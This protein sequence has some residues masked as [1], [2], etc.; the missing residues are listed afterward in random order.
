[1]ASTP[2]K[3]RKNSSLVWRHA[4]K[5]FRENGTVKHIKC[6]HCEKTFSYVGRSTANALNHLYRT[7]FNHLAPSECRKCSKNTSFCIDCVSDI[8]SSTNMCYVCE[9]DAI[10]NHLRTHTGEKA[11]QCLQC[12]KKFSQKEHLVKH[13]RTHT[14]EKPY[15]CL[16]CDKKF[17]QKEHLVRH[18]RMHTGEKPFQCL[19]C[20]K[21]FSQKVKLVKHQNIHTRE[22]TFQCLQC[23]KKFSQK[24]YLVKHIRTH[25]GEKAYQCLQCDNKF[26]QKEYMRTM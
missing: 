1:M 15:Q 5:I 17:S 12:D 4:R 21:K 8:T 19:L 9:M 26:S 23:D 14:G 20:D 11:Y 16:L 7:H 25:T 24:E 6:N 18:L 2:R 10:V 22:K 3:K 13:I